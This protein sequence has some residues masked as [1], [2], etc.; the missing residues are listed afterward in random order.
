[1]LVALGEEVAVALLE[2]K[3][4]TSLKGGTVAV[5]V[6]GG[7]RKPWLKEEEEEFLSK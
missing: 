6:W 7:R 3:L 2:G 4:A 1:V 5:T